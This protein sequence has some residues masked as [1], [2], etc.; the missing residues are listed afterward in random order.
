MKTQTLLIVGALGLGAVLIYIMTRPSKT[1][2]TTPRPQ[3]AGN[4][5]VAGTGVSGSDINSWAQTA[6][7]GISWLANAFGS[8]SDSSSSG[9]S[10]FSVDDDY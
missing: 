9:G 3:T 2:A 1:T 4:G 5:G 8:S 10:G 7:Q 6:G